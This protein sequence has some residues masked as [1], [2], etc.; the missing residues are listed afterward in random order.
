MN[1]FLIFVVIII[2]TQNCIKEADNRL[3][4]NNLNSTLWMQTAAEYVANSLQTYQTA[5]ERLDSLINDKNHT[6]LIEQ[7]DNYQKLPPAI[8]LD[9]D[10]TVLDNS[11]YDAK[12][13]LDN[14]KHTSAEWNRWVSLEQAEAVPG[15]VKFLNKAQD[16]GITIFF[17][18]NRKCVP[19]DNVE[20]PCPQDEQTFKNLQKVGIQNV[21]IENVLLQN[22]QETWKK[23][24][25]SRREYVAQN[26][27]VIMLFGDNLADFVSDTA[28]SFKQRESH[29]LKY[30][31]KWGTCWFM[32]ANPM[33]G[34]WHDALIK[35]VEDNFSS[36][37]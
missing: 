13:I 25:T 34:N 6:A 35:P 29:V 10:E 37:K 15:A 5:A 23:D 27:R 19:D 4:H 11:P 32:L 31:D 7:K 9:V 33:Y 16:M 18:T 8:I 1:K 24:K 17:V 30:S 26:Y 2:F 36:Y 14:K 21:K 12:L 28:K 20:N 3:T 22:E